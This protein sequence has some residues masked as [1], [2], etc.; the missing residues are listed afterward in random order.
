M[1]AWKALAKL[2]SAEYIYAVNASWV[3]CLSRWC[4]LRRK[5][6]TMERKTYAEPQPN[7]IMPLNV[8]IRWLKQQHPWL[9]PHSLRQ[10]VM[11]GKVPSIRS[12]AK[13]RARYYV[14]PIDLL[15]AFVG[16]EVK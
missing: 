10:L 12:S 9:P 11:D 8:A 4:Q 1:S 3:A 15:N 5:E 16:C 13:K 7:Q 6:L 14:K 2:T